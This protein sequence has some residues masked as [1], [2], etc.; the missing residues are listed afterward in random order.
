[1]DQYNRAI[2]H[3]DQFRKNGAGKW[4]S[5]SGAN[6]AH[7]TLNRRLGTQTNF[8]WAEILYTHSRHLKLSFD[9]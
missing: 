7:L 3:L 8:D 6:F 1:M 9:F 5:F 4:D 2:F